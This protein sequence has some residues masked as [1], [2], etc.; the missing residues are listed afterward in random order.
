MPHVGAHF[1]HRACEL[2]AKGHGRTDASGGPTIPEVDVEIRSADARRLHLDDDVRRRRAWLC[3]LLEGEPRLRRDLS[4]RLHA[5]ILAGP[6]MSRNY[7]PT[8]GA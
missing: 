4:Q 1:D 3:H 2:V 7:V 8:I 6:L 5:G